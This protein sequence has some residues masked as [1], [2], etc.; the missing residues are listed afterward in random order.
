MLSIGQEPQLLG[1]NPE[2][3]TRHPVVLLDAALLLPVPPVSLV[4]VFLEEEEVVAVL[5]EIAAQEAYASL[6]D[7]VEERFKIVLD[8]P[9]E[10]V[11]PL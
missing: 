11:P 2:S 1:A 4:E 6:E 8:V 5:L 9:R 7:D 10:P 3:P